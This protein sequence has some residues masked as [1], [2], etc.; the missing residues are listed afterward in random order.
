MTVTVTVKTHAWAANV[1]IRQVTEGQE[2]HNIDESS[3]EISPGSTQIFHV[4]D[5]SELVIREIRPQ[6]EI[7]KARPFE[8]EKV[9]GA[10]QNDKLIKPAGRGQTA[11]ASSETNDED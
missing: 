11:K 2:G 7:E 4:T 9:P 6:S 5:P 10:E 1:T 3:H 8:G